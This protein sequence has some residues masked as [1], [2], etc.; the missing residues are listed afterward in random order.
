MNIP[1]EAAAESSAVAAEATV[2]VYSLA[3]SAVAEAVPDTVAEEWVAKTAEEFG[4]IGQCRSP[5]AHQLPDCSV[6]LAFARP[7]DPVMVSI[8]CLKPVVTIVRPEQCRI[9]PTGSS[10]LVL[11]MPDTSARS[12][13]G[14]G[15]LRCE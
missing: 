5:E 6:Q 14:T 11:S 9:R 3:S 13:M 15:T 8:R 10:R 12:G 7:L 4:A 2:S 1:E